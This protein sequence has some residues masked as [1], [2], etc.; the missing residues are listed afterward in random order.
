MVGIHQ[1]CLRGWSLSKDRREMVVP[2]SFD[3]NQSYAS[4]QWLWKDVTE[5]R[6]EE[7]RM[8][9][10]EREMGNGE[11]EIE[12]GQREMKNRQWKMENGK[13][14]MESGR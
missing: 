11:W 13:W 6:Y 14:E 2:L 9:S 12:D 10:E 5:R 4:N 8:G 7:W 1:F 3:T